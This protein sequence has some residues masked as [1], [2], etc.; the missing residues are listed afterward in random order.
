MPSSDQHTKQA[1]H[2]ESLLS[3]LEQQARHI[4][5]GDWYVTIA[6]YAAVHRIEAVLFT[7]KIR[8]ERH[9]CQA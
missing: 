9:C 1:I 4:D 7:K 8:T 6:F 5:Y 2:N 3:L